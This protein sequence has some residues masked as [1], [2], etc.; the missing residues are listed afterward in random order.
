MVDKDVILAVLQSGIA[1]AGLLLIFS[2]FLFAKANSY[3][4]ARGDKYKLL[5]KATLL[6]VLISLAL[7]WV[8]VDALQGAAW[9]KDNLLLFVRITLAAT[10]V[11]AVVGVLIGDP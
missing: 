9:A 10:A 5:A 4:S 3:S 11:F 6:P 7:S 1:L 8:C 2:T